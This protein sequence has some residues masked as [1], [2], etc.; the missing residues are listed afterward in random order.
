V[1]T[2]ASNS[3]SPILDSQNAPVLA[4]DDEVDLPVPMAAGVA[5]HIWSLEEIAVLLD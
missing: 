1:I 3:S 2:I 4:L 5:G